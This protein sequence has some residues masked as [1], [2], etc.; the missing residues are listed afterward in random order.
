MGP[1]GVPGEPGEPGADGI[2]GTAGPAGPTGATGAAGPPGSP[3]NTSEMEAIRAQLELLLRTGAPTAATSTSTTTAATEDRAASSTSTRNDGGDDGL[4]LAA[5]GLAC[6]ALIM[7]AVLAIQIH[8]LS[9]QLRTL[10]VRL[11]EV[12]R[13]G[14]SA[15]GVGLNQA[16]SDGQAYGHDDTSPRSLSA[17]ATRGAGAANPVYSATATSRGPSVANPVYSVTPT[18]A[19][20]RNDPLTATYSVVFA[21]GDGST[22]GIASA[23]DGVNRYEVPFA[24]GAEGAAVV[25]TRNQMYTQALASDS[26]TTAGIAGAAAGAAPANA[27]PP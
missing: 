21:S 2:D 14:A 3:A 11:W 7:V 13:S 17:V 9:Q 22:G 20:H 18:V 5:L 1:T 23:T 10:D 12:N 15:P 8:R 25:H 4:V 19:G 6:I 16:H 26:M 27:H 24:G